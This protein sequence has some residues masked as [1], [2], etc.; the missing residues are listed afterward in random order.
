[1]RGRFTLAFLATLALSGAAQ[2]AETV[3]FVGNSYI[4]GALSAVHYYRNDS[5]TDLNAERVGGVPALF[6]LFAREAGRDY[7]VSLETAPGVGLDYHYAN[8]LALIDRRWDH[9][10]LQGYSTLDRDKPGDPASLVKYTALLSSGFAAK[11]P[12]VDIRLVA[13]WSRPDQTYPATGHWTGQPIEAMA[14]DVRAGC[15]LAA[16]G[17]PQ[18]RGV[19]PVG[20]AFSRAIV[21]GLAD[22]NPY[23][24]TAPNQIDLWAWDHY[25]ASAYGYY[26]EALMVFGSLTGVDPQTL[27]AN[28]TA[29][30][31]LGF[32][33]AQTIGLQK[34]AHDQL[35]AE[36][37]L[38]L[39]SGS[40]VK[41]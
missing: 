26:L 34:A 9:V 20:E 39:A 19:I 4:F 7:D 30:M 31:E 36:E 16:Q 41:R 2:A 18:V 35:T 24:G 17:A 38:K 5:V 27:G 13:T 6:K 8:K 1:M 22:P 3:L 21:S 28:E 25:H 15:D 29:A 10:I 23:D 11:N 37:A 14:K 40:P 33:P 32:S 12:A